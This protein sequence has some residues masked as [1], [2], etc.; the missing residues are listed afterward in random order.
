[1]KYSVIIAQR[2]EPDL[3]NT[4]DNIKAT[5]ANAE[6]IVIND[7]SGKGPQYCRN[8]G[9]H[10]STT[11][12]VIV[13]DAHMRFAK[14]ALDDMAEYIAKNPDHVAC[15]KCHHNSTMDLKD[16][17]YMGARFCWKSQELN[18]Y[19][20]MHGKWRSETTT[21]EIG[22]V[23]GACYAFNRSRYIEVLKSPWRF[24]KGWGMDEET[25]SLSNWLSGGKVML[26][27]IDV[28]HLAR[29]GSQVPFIYSPQQFDGVWANRLA[30]LRMFPI[31]AAETEEL[32]QWLCQNNIMQNRWNEINGL[33]DHRGLSDIRDHYATFKRSF[34]DWKTNT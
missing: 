19:W 12:I 17:P 14:G 31:P 15:A 1:M 30:L 10:S 7:K 6:T 3:Q 2:N 13:I 20:I 21:G 18:Q 32:V 16:N 24:G 5:Q 34:I 8:T 22:C 4:L 27:D 26:L 23:M 9:I 33:L 28:A 29:T 11:E 25:L